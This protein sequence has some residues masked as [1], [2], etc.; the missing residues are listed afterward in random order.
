MFS[1]VCAS[2]AAL[3]SVLRSLFSALLQLDVRIQGQLLGCA[4]VSLFVVQVSIFLHAVV[5]LQASPRFSAVDALS[6][7]RQIP[8]RRRMADR[9]A[10]CQVASTQAAISENESTKVFVTLASLWLCRL[11]KLSCG[12]LRLVGRTPKQ[13][14]EDPLPDL[15]GGGQSEAE[16][17]KRLLAGL[18]ELLR[19][20]TSSPL[21]RREEGV[22]RR[23]RSVTS[24]DRKIGVPSAKLSVRTVW[25]VVCRD[26]W[27]ACQS[28][29]SVTLWSS[30]TTSRR[31]SLFTHRHRTGTGG[32]H[33]THHPDMERAR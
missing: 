20:V 30:Q 26:L 32:A 21:A 29:H 15:W 18:G 24:T 5:G 16:L 17:N 7:S 8:G 14:C 3:E 4:V 19:S 13:Q 6:P 31:R 1:S 28:G 9:Q 10:T 27:V 11:A 12:P 22:R 2:F 33:G 23:S 25:W